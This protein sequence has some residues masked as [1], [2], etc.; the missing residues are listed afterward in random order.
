MQQCEPVNVMAD[1]ADRSTDESSS[2]PHKM[3][4]RE[5]TASTQRHTQQR[6]WSCSSRDSAVWLVYYIELQCQLW[7]LGTP[8]TQLVA[9]VEDTYDTYNN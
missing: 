9:C 1:R 4:K 3:S 8:N 5:R 7:S 6:T 2:Q